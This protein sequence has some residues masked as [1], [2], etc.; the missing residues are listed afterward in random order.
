[1]DS[2]TRAE[3]DLSLLA[4]AAAPK[5][6]KVFASTDRT[7]Q[8]VRGKGKPTCKKN[9]VGDSAQAMTSANRAKSAKSKLKRT[10]ADPFCD[11]LTTH[12]SQPLPAQKASHAP[13]NEA[14]HNAGRLKKDKQEIRAVGDIGSRDGLR[15]P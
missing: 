9:A 6:V 12:S 7:L 11:V 8:S 4:A 14:S 15:R 5:E 1:M 3:R 2:S 13:E 10:G